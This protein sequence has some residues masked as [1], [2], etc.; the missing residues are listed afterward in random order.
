MKNLRWTDTKKSK[1]GVDSTETAGQEMGTSAAPLW[2]EKPVGLRS[3]RHEVS[4]R[5]FSNL[6]LESVMC[7][8][9]RTQ[10]YLFFL[11]YNH[12][13]SW[14]EKQCWL[15]ACFTDEN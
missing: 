1:S 7:Q 15:L 3:E 10:F 6:K 13:D 5:E 9:L 4:L 11:F 14:K 12:K 8:A 2:S